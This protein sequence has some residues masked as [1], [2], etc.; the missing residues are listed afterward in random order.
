MSFLNDFGKKVTDIAQNAGKITKEAAEVAR[1]NGKKQ[2]IY[3]QIEGLYGDL[4]RKYYSNRKGDLSEA[5]A[6]CEQIASLKGEI[7]HLTQQVDKIRKQKRCP[8]CGQPLTGNAKF[9]ANCGAKLPEVV[10]NTTAK[11]AVV[12]KPA[13]PEEI[14]EV[15]PVEEAQD[16]SA[17]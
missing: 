7:D 12:P 11:A 10:E 13:E 17:E 3:Q 8:G 5:D 6:L 9:C 2:S 14:P 1:L 4:G 16:T 15:A